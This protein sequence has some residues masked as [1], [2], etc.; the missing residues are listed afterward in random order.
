MCKPG[1][2]P[3]CTP[4][5]GLPLARPIVVRFVPIVRCKIQIRT[6]MTWFVPISR[7]AHR[8]ATLPVEKPA[9]SAPTLSLGD[10]GGGRRDDGHG[11]EPDKQRSD[12]THLPSSI[13]TS[14]ARCAHYDSANKRLLRFSAHLHQYLPE[15]LQPS[16][17]LTAMGQ[18]R[19][20]RRVGSWRGVGG[21]RG[22]LKKE[23][24][25]RLSRRHHRFNNSGSLAMLPA[26]RR[27]SSR[28]SSLPVAR[29]P[30]HPRNI[31]MTPPARWRRAR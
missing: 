23:R 2:T 17:S 22:G 8:H 3:K 21:R 15:R 4:P 12:L 19:R 6:A 29:R 31:R 16:G 20:I 28:V 30:G 7:F 26:M 24:G 5:L 9:T 13:F 25:P 10:R 27:A 18:A 11:S 1:P 14:S